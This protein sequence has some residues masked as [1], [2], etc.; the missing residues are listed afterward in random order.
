MLKAEKVD[1]ELSPWLAGENLVIASRVHGHHLESVS[2]P[3]MELIDEYIHYNSPVFETHIA[4][5]NKQEAM[6]IVGTLRLAAKRLE[7]AIR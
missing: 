4:E 3:F 5:A 1:F 2:I 6:A 7:E